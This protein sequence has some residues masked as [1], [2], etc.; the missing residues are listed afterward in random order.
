MRTLGRGIVVSRTRIL[1]NAARRGDSG[2]RL[3]VWLEG[4][5][6]ADAQTETLDS[7]VGEHIL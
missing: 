3:Q 6:G 5:P 2:F 1:G 4:Q 7:V